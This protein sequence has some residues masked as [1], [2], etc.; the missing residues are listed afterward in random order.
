VPGNS[1]LQRS[2]AGVFEGVQ[3]GFLDPNSFKMCEMEGS[4]QNIVNGLAQ[5]LS[6][7]NAPRELFQTI[8]ILQVEAIQ[9]LTLNRAI[10]I[11]E[12]ADHASAFI[13]RPANGHFESVVVA[14]SVRV[15]ALAVSG[16]VLLAGH[17]IAM[18][19]M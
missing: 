18:Q 4:L 3:H 15:V 1:K 7:G 16:H 9:Y 5:V 19:P 2:T 6:G 14:M 17:G 13:Y 8:Q 10:K 12:I 11:D